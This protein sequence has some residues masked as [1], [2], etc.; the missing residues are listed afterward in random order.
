[1]FAIP[2]TMVRKM[3]GPI[4]IFTSFTKVSPTGR[5]ARARDGS[6]TPSRA[7]SETAQ[8]TWKVRFPA[9][10]L[11]STSPGSA[12]PGEQDGRP[13]AQE[14]GEEEQ[15]EEEAQGPERLARDVARPEVHGRGA[16]GVRCKDAHHPQR[17]AG[18][19]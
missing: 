15:P 5:I 17:V 14:D 4:T 3:M 11:I 2:R 1:M 10:R 16:G 9:R 8:S 12:I 18:E 13:D 19:H 7:P 6:S